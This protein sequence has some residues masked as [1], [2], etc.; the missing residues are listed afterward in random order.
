MTEKQKQQY[1]DL[2]NG[3]RLLVSEGSVQAPSLD[4]LA[5]LER[6]GLMQSKLIDR[7]RLER[8][9][10]Y[11]TEPMRQQEFYDRARKDLAAFAV[12][13]ELLQNVVYEAIRWK[14]GLVPDSVLKNVV[15]NF[16]RTPVNR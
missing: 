15:D 5:I 6:H 14:M 2:M 7:Q 4:A 9:K 3:V 16:L 8:V 11:L 12:E 10:L 1:A 13:V